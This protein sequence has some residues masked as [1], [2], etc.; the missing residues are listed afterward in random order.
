MSVDRAERIA[1]AVEFLENPGDRG[2]IHRTIL[3]IM[4]QVL[5]ADIGDVGVFGILGEQVIKG[6]IFLR[7]HVGGDRLVPLLG[8]C[9]D[10]IYIE[11][12]PPKI[13]DPVPHDIPY[14]ETGRGDGGGACRRWAVGW[15]QYVSHFRRIGHRLQ[16]RNRLPSMTTKAQA[17]QASRD[18]LSARFPKDLR[19]VRPGQPLRRGG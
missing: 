5:L 2:V 17:W 8:I 10:R 18:P 6:L 16:R 12:N 1:S 4:Q 15:V 19:L 11:H 7:P 14:S 13:E 3:V 9:K